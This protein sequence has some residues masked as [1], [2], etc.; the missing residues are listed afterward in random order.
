M[1]QNPDLAIAAAPI[2]STP[3]SSAIAV[4]KGNKEFIDKINKIL[5]E[6][7]ESGKLDEFY[8]ENTKLM[9]EKVSA[10]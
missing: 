7:E 9:E 8:E 3:N 10:E 2:E 6:L 5:I 1:K 4:Q